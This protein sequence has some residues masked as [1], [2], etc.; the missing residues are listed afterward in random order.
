M[1]KFKKIRKSLRTMLLAAF[2]MG[3]AQ[4]NDFDDSYAN[5]TF[6]TNGYSLDQDWSKGI[7]DVEF[8]VSKYKLLANANNMNN[9]N[10]DGT[11]SM[12][13]I[14]TNFNIS[15][16]FNLK[17]GIVPSFAWG[18]INSKLEDEPNILTMDFNWKF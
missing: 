3:G 11:A 6:D 14:Y 10:K 18:A 13:H 2:V 16:T 8:G 1:S 7:E 17:V 12:T 9:V 4:A 5:A 15:K